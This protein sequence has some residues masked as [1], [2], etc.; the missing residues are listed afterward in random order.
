MKRVHGKKNK[1]PKPFKTDLLY[2]GILHVTVDQDRFRAEK[3]IPPDEDAEHDIP[4]RWESKT[5]DGLFEAEDE[6]GG[7]LKD[8]CGQNSEKLTKSLI[9]D[10]PRW[11][12][13]I[14]A[15]ET[16]PQQARKSLGLK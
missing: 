4:Q 10:D 1:Y 3:E 13:F 2:G 11:R 6:W 12:A 16:P 15:K 5:F 9:H 14:G 8:E 7:L